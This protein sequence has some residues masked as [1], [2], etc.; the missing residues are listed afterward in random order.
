M[1][2]AHLLADDSPEPARGSMVDPPAR[3][4]SPAAYGLRVSRQFAQC[5]RAGAQLALLW[6]EVDLLEQP[7]SAI[8]DEQRDSVLQTVSLRLRN[9]VRGTDDVQ[10]V[11]ERGF[12]V[13][14]L[15]ARA[16]EAEIAEQRLLQ[17]LRGAYGFDARIMQVGVRMGTAVFPEA[18]RNGAELVEAARRGLRV[19]A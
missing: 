7:G 11:G 2:P 1:P 10:R 3:V 6:I 9:R 18:G 12:A 16:N 19:G 17:A 15:S 14:L 8:S 5:R 13:L 4:D